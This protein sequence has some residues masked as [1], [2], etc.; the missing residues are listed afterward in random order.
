MWYEAKNQLFFVYHPSVASTRFPEPRILKA[1][2]SALSL[3]ARHY[4][5]NGNFRT[6]WNSTAANVG[7][8]LAVTLDPMKVGS[9]RDN[10]GSISCV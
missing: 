8:I 7:S 1:L 3:Y 6:T 5:I 4:V 10:S 2:W 9:N